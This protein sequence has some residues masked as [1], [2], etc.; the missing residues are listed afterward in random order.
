MNRCD[1]ITGRKFQF[2]VANAVRSDANKHVLFIRYLARQYCIP[3]SELSSFCGR[4]T[5][6]LTFMSTI[7]VLRL[8]PKFTLFSFCDV[9]CLGR[10]HDAL[11]GGMPV[12]NAENPQTVFARPNAQSQSVPFLSV[13]TK[14]KYTATGLWNM[15]RHT[16]L[17]IACFAFL[18]QEQPAVVY[19]SL[20]LGY[21]I[22]NIGKVNVDS[23]FG[24]LVVSAVF[25]PVA[26]VARSGKT[27]CLP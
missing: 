24:N 20:E 5:E 3:V 9:V 12:G 2:I 6:I 13:P 16:E 18:R 10:C 4:T 27:R 15:A 8:N 21:N 14:L 22:V 17:L 7:V 1:R 25:R 19:E 23:R 26:A 11:L